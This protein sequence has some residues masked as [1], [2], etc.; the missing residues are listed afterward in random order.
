MLTIPGKIPI[1]IHPF[2]WLIAGLIGWLTS[3]SALG[4]GLW[5]LVITVSILLHEFGHALTARYFGQT[6]EINLVALGGETYRRGNPLKFWQEFLVVLDGP[7]MGF[8]L[9]AIS[10]MLLKH[11]TEES[12]IILRYLLTVFS[13]VNFY[14]T[15]INL[16]PIQPLDGGRLLSII[17]EGAFGLTGLKVALFLSVLFSILVSVFFFTSGNLLVGSLFLLFTYES[18]QT[19]RNTL[20]LMPSDRD[21]SLQDLL[22]DAED[23]LRHGHHDEAWSRLTEIRR[24]TNEG[25]IYVKA[26]QYIA[27]L[28]AAEQR[29]S[30]AYE[31]LAPIQKQLD[32]EH[33][34][35]FHQL[36][37]RN[38][39]WKT[40]IELGNRIYRSYPG[41][42]T[43]LINAYCYSMLG[44][45]EP[46]IGWLQC[47]IRDGLPNI[48]VVLHRPEFN[49]IRSDPRFLSLYNNME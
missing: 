31:L 39:D 33:L 41:Y 19:W 35:L 23:D 29:F 45:V 20:P 13:Y 47:A 44:E 5:V 21:E 24:L 11:M 4:T 30:E 25:R 17:L 48:R 15:L 38:K 28:L 34:H 9:F 8:L 22:K 42:D 7:L 36:A 10:F 18:F 16:L 1:R 6:A 40:A 2:F 32:P 26:T 46:A 14:W 43:A 3:Q 12:S 37:Y 49:Q 27:V